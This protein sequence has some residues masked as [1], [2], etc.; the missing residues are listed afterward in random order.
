MPQ[1]HNGEKPA[2]YFP[3]DIQTGSMKFGFK[4]T[5]V[6]Q[7]PGRNYTGQHRLSRITGTILAVQ[8]GFQVETWYQSYQVAV[9][10]IH[11]IQFK[12]C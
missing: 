1:D 4:R 6:V 10:C 12:Y 9:D 3:F 8:S 2:L 7:Q 11:Q 5:R